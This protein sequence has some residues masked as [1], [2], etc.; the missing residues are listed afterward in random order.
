MGSGA[1]S[2]FLSL[3]KLRLAAGPVPGLASRARL[4]DSV[5]EPW[6]GKVHLSAFGVRSAEH[7]GCFNQ[8]LYFCSGLDPASDSGSHLAAPAT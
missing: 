2:P 8:T 4:T 1:V 5:A 6:P 7:V 3:A